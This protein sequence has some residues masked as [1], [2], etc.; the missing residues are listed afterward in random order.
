MNTINLLSRKGADAGTDFRR[1]CPQVRG[2]LAVAGLTVLPL[3]LALAPSA[4]SAAAAPAIRTAP[5]AASA[6]PVPATKAS[7]GILPPGNPPA[8]IAPNPN[9]LNDCS[10]SQYDDSTGCVNATLQAIA[11]GRQAEGLPGMILPTDWYQLSPQEQLFVSTNLERTVR[12]LP[13]LTAMATSLDQSAQIGAAQSNDPSP[14]AGFPWSQWGSNW[15]GAVGNPLE[16]D[17]FWMYD[18]GLGS[19]N[20]DCTTSD[21]SGCWGHRDNVLLALSCTPCEMGTGYVSTGYEGYPSWAELLVDTS[22]APAVDFSWSQV[23]PYLPGNAGGA[24]LTAPAVG[25][26]ATPNGGGYWLVSANGG[27]F[28]FGNAT[29]YNSLAGVHL[30]A[31]IV[32][33]A[34]TPDGH[35]YWLVAADGGIFAFGDAGYYGSMGGRPLHKPVVGIAATPNGRGYWEVASVGGI[36]AFG[37]A[38]FH[39]STGGITL[40]KPVVAMQ[41]TPDGNGYWMV[42]SDGGIFS[43]GNATFHGSTGGITLD[44]PVVGMTASTQVGYWLAA[45]DGGVFSFGVPFHGSIG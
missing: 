40:N 32:G 15:A 28:S 37:D 2:L 27:V 8:N 33:I 36:F 26:A 25:I 10:G 22:G 41:S 24:A 38:P 6:P 16:A 17:F 1:P 31:P 20:I 4:S 30:S 7:Q 18:D 11:N 13:A 5:A 19:S 39:G 44:S 12:G 34:S 23:T 29:F 3:V 21:P 45:S 9:F 43:F 42:A 14:A 35:G